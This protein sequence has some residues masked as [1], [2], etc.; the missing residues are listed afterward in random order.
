M[1]PSPRTQAPGCR[2]AFCSARGCSPGLEQGLGD[3]VNASPG[4]GGVSE[5]GPIPSKPGLA[6]TGDVAA[7]CQP[8]QRGGVGAQPWEDGGVWVGRW[9]GWATVA[10]SSEGAPGG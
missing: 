10:R 8:L 4:L 3:W 2:R 9:P 6:Q 7:A 1:S 5:V